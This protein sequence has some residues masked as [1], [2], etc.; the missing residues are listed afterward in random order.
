MHSWPVVMRGAR[1]AGTASRSIESL[2]AVW[3]LVHETWSAN[4][5][6]AEMRYAE[7]AYVTGPLRPLSLS[8]SPELCDQS[9]AIFCCE[10]TASETMPYLLESTVDGANEHY[11]C[12]Q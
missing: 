6:V 9:T 4:A 10:A 8:T 3:E 12:I 2:L 11:L 5:A 7:Y 1:M